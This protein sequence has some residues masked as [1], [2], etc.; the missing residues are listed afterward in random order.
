MKNIT[1]LTNKTS[2]LKIKI[3]VIK[4]EKQDNCNKMYLKD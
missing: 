1:N 2:L 3:I 4:Q